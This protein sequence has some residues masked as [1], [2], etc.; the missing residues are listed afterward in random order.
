MNEAA[1]FLMCFLFGAVL[2]VFF[3][4]GLLWTVQKGLT[5]G[6]PALFFCI[7]YLARLSIVLCGLYW[8]SGGHFERILSSLAG[9]LLV[10]FLFCRGVR[11]ERDGA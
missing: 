3:F 1:V 11:R 7:S 6:R 10:R 8:I 5:V 9:F 4:G 2:G